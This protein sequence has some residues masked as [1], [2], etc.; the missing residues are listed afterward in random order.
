MKTIKIQAMEHSTAAEAIQWAHA[1]AR[2]QAIRVDGKYLT[3]GSETYDATLDR[4]TGAGVEF[5]FLCDRDMPAGGYRTI[6]VPV[7]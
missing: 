1:D 5:A 6:T 7:N 4:M 3:V 2:C